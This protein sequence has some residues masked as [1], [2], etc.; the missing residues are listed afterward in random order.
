M[1]SGNSTSFTVTPNTGYKIASVTGCGGSLSGSIYTTGSITSNCSVSASFSQK[2]YTVTA[3]SLDTNKGSVTPA[4]QTVTHGNTTSFTLSPNTGYSIFGISTGCGG[5]PTTTLTTNAITDNCNISVSF[6]S[7][8]PELATISNQNATQGQAYSLAL[9]SLVTATDG[10]SITSY[11]ITGTLPTGVTLNTST[12]VLSGTPSQSGTYNLSATAS[13]KDGASDARS[14]TLTVAAPPPT[15]TLS[16]TAD[17]LEGNNLTFTVTLDAA[18]NGITTANISYSAP[19]P[20]P[21]GTIAATGAVSCTGNADYSNATTSVDIASGQT[22]ATFTVPTCVN[23]SN[24]QA[25]SVN[26]TLSS[27]S[28]N[29]QLSSTASNI[30]KDAIIHNTTATG[31]LN[32]TGIVITYLTTSNAAQEDASYGRDAQAM[33]GKLAKVGSSS[34]NAGKNNGFDFTKISSTGQPLAADATSWDCVLDNNT[35]LMWENKTDDNGL[36]DKDHTYSWYNSDSSNN[37][38]NAGVESGGTCYQT[39]RCDTEKYVADVNTAGLCGYN[40]WRMPTVEEL[41][42]IADMGRVNPAID[43]SYFPTPP[44]RGYWSSSAFAE[45]TDGAWY[46]LISVVNWGMKESGFAVRLVRKEEVDPAP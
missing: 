34:Q 8:P 7:E 45:G 14:F 26:V 20:L 12:G 40:N 1:Q 38:G 33:A 5:T 23:S 43:T 15:A 36:R 37:G 30:S 31:K 4:S 2:T 39:G 28:G 13:D 25:S 6:G 22:S 29:A 9:A 35:G 16:K 10:D 3:T 21:S 41:P 44:D 32:D 18:A 11:A 27:I 17:A 46:D 19:N 24:L 42:G